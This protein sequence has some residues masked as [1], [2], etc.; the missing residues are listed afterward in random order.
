MSSSRQTALA[1]VLVGLV[2]ALLTVSCAT[3]P[4][5]DLG[6]AAVLGPDEGAL[7]VRFHAVQATGLLAIH[8]GAV[9]LPYAAFA[10]QPNEDLKVVKIKAA[11]GLR[12]STYK[13]GNK[14]AYFDNTKLNFDVRPQ[15][16]TY[17]GDVFVDEQA[18]YV[19]LRLADNEATTR[20]LAVSIYPS[21]FARYGYA[22]YIPGIKKQ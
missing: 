15:T 9:S 20:A 11:E 6:D 10:I 22:K 16:I 2:A 19:G 21:L 5:P 3:K 8:H 14:M 13:V 12:I 1:S 18:K 4:S 7:L 17:I